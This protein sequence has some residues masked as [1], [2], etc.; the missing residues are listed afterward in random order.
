VVARESVALHSEAV[1]KPWT[2]RSVEAAPVNSPSSGGTLDA[3]ISASVNGTLKRLFDL[4]L[5]SL[6]LL[7]G[8]PLMLFIATLVLMDVGTPILFRQ[9]RPGRDAKRFVM[10][11]FRTMTDDHS[12]LGELLP[13]ELRITTFGRFLRSTSLDELPELFN[14]LRGDMS[15]VG[16]R[17]LSEKYLPRYSPFQARRHLCRPGI[18]GLAQVSGRNALSWDAR[19]RLDVWYVQNHSHWLDLQILFRTLLL[20][21]K[22]R[23]VMPAGT[24]EVDSFLE[25]DG[26]VESAKDI[27]PDQKGAGRHILEGDDS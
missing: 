20:T 16:P 8:M 11:K 25:S 13:D 19:F 22:R 12:R 1:F 23:D 10:Y 2:V 15:L 21:L 3:A 17:P 18:T 4:G 9:R 26:R 6:G 5:S 7:V 24:S 14:V 27:S